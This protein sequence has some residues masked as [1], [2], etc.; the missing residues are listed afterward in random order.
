DAAAQPPRE[1][2]RR[3]AGG[4][5][6]PGLQIAAQ[7]AERL[8]NT[9]AVQELHARPRAAARQCL[10]LQGPGLL[11]GARND[12]QGARASGPAANDAGSRRRLCAGL[13]VPTEE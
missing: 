8:A 9:A 1:G 4:D 12:R 11:G 13:R 5:G 10:R 6:A 3:A 2:W 7:E